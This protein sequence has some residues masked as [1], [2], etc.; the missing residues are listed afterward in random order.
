MINALKDRINNS[1][2]S[3]III[4]LC[5]YDQNI[6]FS[7]FHNCLYFF[8]TL[9]QNVLYVLDIIKLCLKILLYPCRFLIV[10]F[11]RYFLFGVKLF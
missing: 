2:V 5:F 4:T 11:Q 6:L 9:F 10:L 7:F 8:G 3:L 1:L